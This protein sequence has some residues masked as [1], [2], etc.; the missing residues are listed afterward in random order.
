[1]TVA[2]IIDLAHDAVAKGVATE[3]DSPVP[4]RPLAGRRGRAR[5]ARRPGGR[6]AHPSSPPAHAPHTNG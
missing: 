3:E 4:A 5:P 2:R 6:C 1:R